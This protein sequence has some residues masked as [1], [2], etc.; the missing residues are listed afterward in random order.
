M[1]R[2]SGMD[3]SGRVAQVWVIDWPLHAGTEWNDWLDREIS[4]HLQPLQLPVSAWLSLISR[5]TL[6]STFHASNPPLDEWAL[7]RDTLRLRLF[8]EGSSLATWGRSTGAR[9]GKDQG[10]SLLKSSAEKPRGGA[11]SR[12][13]RPASGLARSILRLPDW[14]DLDDLKNCGLDYGLALNWN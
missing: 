10:G 9:F 6:I 8:G 13:Q 14:I 5:T 4:G 12:W 1:V 11:S 7:Y 3:D 2:A